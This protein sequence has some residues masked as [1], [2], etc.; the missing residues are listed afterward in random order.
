MSRILK[1][2]ICKIIY[3]TGLAP[4]PFGKYCTLALCTPNH[5]HAKQLKKGDWIIGHSGIKNNF[6]LLYAMRLS[7]NMIS[8]DEYY[9]DSRF[10]YKRPN[11]FGSKEEKAGDNM[12][13]LV[14]GIYEQDKKA[15]YHTTNDKIEKDIKGNRVF[16]SD[17]FFYLGEKRDNNFPELFPRLICNSRNFNY[18][19]DE[20]LINKFVKWLE[21]NFKLRMNAKPCDF[22]KNI[23]KCK[24]C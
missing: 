15:F 9:K 20:K 6:K 17:Y 13:H 8:L 23:D 2:L 7:E 3:D 5:G 14:N 11:K 18:V 19:Y 16:I 4:N 24:N 21:N 22:M 12:Y 10:K 1:A